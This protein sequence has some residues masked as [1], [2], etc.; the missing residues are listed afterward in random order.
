MSQ[1]T[2]NIIAIVCLVVS[3]VLVC[4]GQS[5][6]G[7][8]G[9]VLELIGLAGLLILLYMYDHLDVENLQH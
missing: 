9:L 7:Y 3:F 6:V 1:I 4:Y 8:T 5:L 2:K